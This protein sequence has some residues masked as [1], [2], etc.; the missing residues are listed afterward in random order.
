MKLKK[1]ET[2]TVIGLNKY[3]KKDLNKYQ[4]TFIKGSPDGYHLLGL[5]N[6][7][8]QNGVKK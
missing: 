5:F 8:F 7:F 1:I 3:G 4:G 2:Y 6:E